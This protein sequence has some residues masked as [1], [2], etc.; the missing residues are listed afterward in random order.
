MKTQQFKTN[1]K[2]GACVQAITPEMEKLE[3][4]SWAVDLQ[5]KDRILTVTG[6]LDKESILEALKKSGY[7]GESI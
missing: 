6:D 2:C 7:Q 5:D 4:D 3:A 1:V